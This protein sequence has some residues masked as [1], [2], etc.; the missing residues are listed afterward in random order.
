MSRFKISNF[1]LMKSNRRVLSFTFPPTDQMIS[2]LDV[3]KR[4][5]KLK[6]IENVTLKKS[7]DWIWYGREDNWFSNSKLKCWIIFGPM[8]KEEKNLNKTRFLPPKDS[9]AEAWAEWNSLVTKHWKIPASVDL[10]CRSCNRSSVKWKRSL[11]V[12][13]RPFRY[14]DTEP[15]GFPDTWQW[16]SAVWPSSACKKSGCRRTVKGTVRRKTTRG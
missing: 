10:I 12:S 14:Q 6:S 9:R 16:N 15:G 8:Y 2:N 4:R 5:I 7:I 1:D 13:L 11:A 3:Q